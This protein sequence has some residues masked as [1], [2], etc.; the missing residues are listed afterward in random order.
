MGGGARRR[1]KNGGWNG[2]AGEN[3]SERRCNEMSLSFLFGKCVEKGS[4]GHKSSFA[5]ILGCLCLPSC[6][7]YLDG[8]SGH[9]H[10]VELTSSC[11]CCHV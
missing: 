2:T 6:Y 10:L 7:F 5:L 3:S 1:A 11:D 8:K 4:I 9:I